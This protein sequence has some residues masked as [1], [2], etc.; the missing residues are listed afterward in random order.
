M[1]RIIRAKEITIFESCS[2]INIIFMPEWPHGLGNY[3]AIVGEVPIDLTIKKKLEGVHTNAH[4]ASGATF[5]GGSPA[6]LN[7]SSV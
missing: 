1:N 2:K 3:I 7:G 4:T 5:S 6:F